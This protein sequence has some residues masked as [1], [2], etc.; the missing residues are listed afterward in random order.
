MRPIPRRTIL[1]GG[2]LGAAA[3][4]LGS[5]PARG[6][7]GRRVTV[8]LIGAGGWG[9]TT[10]G[11]SPPGATSRSPTSA[12]SIAIAWPRRRRSSRKARARRPRR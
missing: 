6:S 2:A 7:T 12:T 5:E 10:S 3:L 8:G 4:T 1:E 9:A 11:S